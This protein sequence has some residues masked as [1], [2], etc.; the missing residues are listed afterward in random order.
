MDAQSKPRV[1]VVDDDPLLAG[2]IVIPIGRAGA[3]A[4]LAED[5]RTA[6]MRLR[7]APCAVT[8]LDLNLPD[9][10]TE[11]TLEAIPDLLDAGA[12]YIV[13]VTSANVTADLR[14]FALSCG[15]IAVISKGPTFL[16]ELDDTLRRLL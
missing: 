16:E 2:L 4:V 3:Q 1:L 10:P 12:G 11:R 9:S 13:I 14:A 8:L 5:Y 7:A 15:A 6:V